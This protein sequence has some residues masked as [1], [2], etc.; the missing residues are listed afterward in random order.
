MP[1][2]CYSDTRTVFNAL[3]TAVTLGLRELA[4]PAIGAGA[5]NIPLPIAAQ[6]A[7]EAMF[8]MTSDNLPTG[9]P[10]LRLV[11]WVLPDVRTQHVFAAAFNNNNNNKIIKAF[12]HS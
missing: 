12:I 7:A 5:F 8:C 9:V 10:G 4:L 11:R 3:D 1:T 2:V 6:A